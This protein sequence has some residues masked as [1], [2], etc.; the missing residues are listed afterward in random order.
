MTENQRGI[1]EM[2]AQNAPASAII[3]IYPNTSDYKYLCSVYAICYVENEF[4]DIP[5]ILGKGSDFDKFY[6]PSL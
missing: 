6:N 1:L 3:A 4:G 5:C 2:L